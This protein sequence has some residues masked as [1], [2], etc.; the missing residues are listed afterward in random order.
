MQETEAKETFIMSPK[1]DFCFKELMRNSEVRKGFL[2]AVLDI[3]PDK[4][5]ETTLLPTHLE[6]TYAED[7]L[8]IL[9]VQVGMKDG[10]KVDIEINV[11]PFLAWPERSL[12][13]LSKMYAGQIES[14]EKYMV[15]KKCIHIGILDFVLFHGEEEYHSRFHLWEDRR[16][17]LYCDKLEIHIIE[18]PKLKGVHH[19]E[20]ELL[21]WMRFISAERE[22]EMEA[23]AQRNGY[24]QTAY[25]E[26]KL[27]S[28]DER[29]RLAY[30]ERL[31][32]ERDYVSFAYDNWER[33]IKDGVERGKLLQ[34]VKGADR[35]IQKG[36]TEKEAAELLGEEVSLI[37]RIHGWKEK[38]PDLKEE[39]LAEKL[40]NS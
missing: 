28:A 1:V 8:G 9:D 14:G 20:T 25:D 22:E 34:L 30:E 36:F 10:A 18:L 32:A 3:L 40:L 16:R 29:K 21:D 19:P 5:E 37:Q 27:L 38:F 17:F 6:K 12:F 33:G 35:M 39:E 13:Y 2:S 4:I 23:M 11:A 31:K 24:I 26:L 15:L 7:K